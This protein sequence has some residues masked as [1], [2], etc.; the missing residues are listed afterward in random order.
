MV[1]FSGFLI[2]MRP[3]TVIRSDCFVRGSSVLVAIFLHE[4]G[5]V[6]S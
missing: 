2:F 3:F 5:G 1:T 6:V 4:G